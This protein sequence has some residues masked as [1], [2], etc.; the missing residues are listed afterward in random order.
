M[1][2]AA[3]TP[4]APDILVML[5]VPHQFAHLVAVARH[6]LISVA[7]TTTTKT[8][9][10]APYRHT[11]AAMLLERL[12]AE[13]PTIA[14]RIEQIRVQLAR[15]TG[16]H[17]EAAAQ[18]VRAA[19]ADLPLSGRVEAALRREPLTTDAL[20]REV[21]APV[22]PVTAQLRRLRI[23]KHLSNIGSEHTP[24]WVL[25]FA[26]EGTPDEVSTREAYERVWQLISIRPFLSSEIE[27]VTGL[28]R[29]R[30]QGA[31]VDAQRLGGTVVHAAG[32]TRAR[33]RWFLVAPPPPA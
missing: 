21:R 18:A 31:L 28:R 13:D 32:S 3:A 29:G 30:V 14:T 23:A 9:T 5:R 11:D 33:V 26:A 20:C 24:I 10:N 22:G 19:E 17:A 16:D 7:M 6:V 8:K 12:V 27:T 15:G 4:P 2:C 1:P 25:R